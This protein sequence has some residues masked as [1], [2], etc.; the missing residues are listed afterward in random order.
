MT[1]KHTLGIITAACL[2]FGGIIIDN[3]VLSSVVTPVA[4]AVTES[5]SWPL[6]GLGLVGLGLAR[7]K[8]RSLDK[9]NLVRYA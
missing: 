8:Q 2:G 7:R 5:A 4:T 6:L 1:T 9:R 3:V